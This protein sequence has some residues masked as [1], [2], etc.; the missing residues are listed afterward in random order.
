MRR[1]SQLVQSGS[2]VDIDSAMTPMID[3]VFLLLVFFVWT[4]SFQIVEQ[5]LPSQLVTESGQQNIDID[6]PPEQSDLDNLVIRIEFDGAAAT[7][8]LQE[9]A[10]ADIEQVSRQLAAIGAISTDVPVILW[11]EK[12]VPLEYVV[13][14]FDAAKSSGYSKISYA[15]SGDNQR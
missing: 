10:M 14:A 3:V 4:A 2:D 9:Q 8:I 1:P 12:S 13:A 6:P 15:I 11:P 7:W 5:V